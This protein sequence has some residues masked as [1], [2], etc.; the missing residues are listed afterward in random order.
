[1][2]PQAKKYDNAKKATKLNGGPLE[3][4]PEEKKEENKKKRNTSKCDDQYE[5]SSQ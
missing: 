1:M 3:R 2:L 5:K 4:R